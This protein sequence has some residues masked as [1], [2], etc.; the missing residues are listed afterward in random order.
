MAN[1]FIHMTYFEGAFRGFLNRCGAKIF[2][3]RSSQ[4]FLALL[5]NFLPTHIIFDFLCCAKK[6]MSSKTQIIQRII[7]KS[8]IQQDRGIS[9]VDVALWIL[10]V[11]PKIDEKMA[12]Y[13]TP[14]HALVHTLTTRDM[15][16]KIIA[17][18]DKP[19]NTFINHRKNPHYLTPC[20]YNIFLFLRI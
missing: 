11:A 9:K 18:T 20:I 16:R 12:S 3:A 13:L 19:Q 8:I 10:G 6:I 5:P 7:L 2:R 1:F 17:Y 15:P 14:Q 4:F